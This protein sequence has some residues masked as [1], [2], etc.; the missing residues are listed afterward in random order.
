[1]GRCLLLLLAPVMLAAQDCPLPDLD[2]NGSA[3]GTLE[4]GH[5]VFSDLVPGSTNTAFVDRYRITTR[6]RGVLTLG[7]DSAAF[8]TALYFYDGKGVRLTQNQG[9]G[10][11][12]SRLTLSLNPGTYIAFATSATAASGSYTLASSFEPLRECAPQALAFGVPVSGSLSDADCR[13]LD[14]RVPSADNTYTN[15]FRFTM[16]RRGFVR[17]DL[18][19]TDFSPYLALFDARNHNIAVMDTIIPPPGAHIAL[20]LEPGV[21]TLYANST[22]TATGGYAL[23]ASF[24]EARPC[25]LTDLRVGTAAGGTLA[26]AGCR[27][28]DVLSPQADTTPV[29]LYRLTVTEAAVYTI[30]MASNDFDTYLLIFD[31]QY[32]Y[33]GEAD[34][35]SSGNTNS[36]LIASLSPGAYIVMANTYDD[37][38]A[39]TL[40]VT[41]APFRNRSRGPRCSAQ[42]SIPQISTPGWCSQARRAR[43]SPMTTTAAAARTPASRRSSNPAITTC[44]PTPPATPARTRCARLCAM[45]LPARLRS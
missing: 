42:I 8:D 28:A 32:R 45:R 39:Y 22:R 37:V 24:E 9:T 31:D 41:S 21:Y 2:A 5:C 43:R 17:L 7:L 34:D 14:L 38:G 23:A 11:G 30:D 13:I 35:L 27:L 10:P 6:G 44:S 16:E 29:N 3:A 33:I 4:A 15:A 20:G 19:S 26:T 1:M 18:T 36:R 25:P 12:A 40:Q